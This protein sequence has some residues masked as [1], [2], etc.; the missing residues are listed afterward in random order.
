MMMPEIFYK[1]QNF[2]LRRYI[3]CCHISLNAAIYYILTSC[4]LLLLKLFNFVTQRNIIEASRDE[5]ICS[6]VVCRGMP[7]C[8]R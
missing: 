5:F 7:P 1:L 3:L 8:T 4:R 2:E 6:P